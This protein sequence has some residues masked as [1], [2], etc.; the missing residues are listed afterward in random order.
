MWFSS[1]GSQAYATPFNRDKFADAISRAL[2]QDNT[3]PDISNPNL[4]SLD[5]FLDGATISFDRKAS[6]AGSLFG[7]VNESDI[8]DFLN[9]NNVKFT[10]ITLP[11][12][13]KSI[14][15][16][17]VEIDGTVVPVH[18]KSLQWCEWSIIPFNDNW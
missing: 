18:V 16:H 2:L 3:K 13:L 15:A 10:S 5:V 14:G 8:K 12:P 6:E 1:F 7:S 11:E 9:S 4:L 17:S